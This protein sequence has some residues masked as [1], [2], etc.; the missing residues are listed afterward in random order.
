M[1]TK[2]RTEESKLK[3]ASWRDT[4]HSGGEKSLNQIVIILLALKRT[5]TVD[6]PL[7]TVVGSLLK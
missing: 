2:D 1:R 7:I 3:D 4:V 6:V 5:L